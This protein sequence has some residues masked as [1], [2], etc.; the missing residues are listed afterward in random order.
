MKNIIYI[1][2]LCLTSIAFS[3]NQKS[4]I[5]ASINAKIT[6]GRNG[7]DCSGRGTCSFNTNTNKASANA[8]IISNRDSNII[9]L[10]IDRTKI[11]NQE[12]IKI[13]GQPLSSDS[14][15]KEFAF[16][17]E[18]DFTLEAETKLQL[19][20]P[21]QLTKIAKGTYPISITK[22]TFTITFKLE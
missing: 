5:E 13:I 14:I 21:I 16:I 19:K 20:A 17:M 22:E 9:T 2:L 7:A 8:Q 4:A 15:K 6:F 1:A 10:I 3:Q 12:E 11:T 18:D